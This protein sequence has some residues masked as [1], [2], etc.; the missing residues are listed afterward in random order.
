MAEVSAS[1]APSSHAISITHPSAPHDGFGEQIK[2]V[3]YTMLFAEMNQ[4]KY[5]YTPLSSM[6][7]NYNNNPDFVSEK[8]TFLGWLD[9]FAAAGLVVVPG[10]PKVNLFDLLHFVVTNIDKLATSPSLA[11]LREWFW[12]TREENPE[13]NPVLV[14][15]R[16]HRIVLHIRQGNPHDRHAASFQLPWNIYAEIIAHLRRLGTTEHTLEIISQGSLPAD[17]TDSVD[18]VYLDEPLETSFMRMVTA[19]IL[20]VGPSAFSYAA[21]LLAWP[22]KTLVYYMPHCNPPLPNWQIIQNLTT[23]RMHFEYII[24]MT[25]WFDAAR[26]SFRP[27]YEVGFPFR[28]VTDLCRWGG[29]NSIIMGAPDRLP[30]NGNPEFNEICTDYIRGFGIDTIIE[31]GTYLGRTTEFFAKCPGVTTVHS[32]ESNLEYLEKARAWLGAA[33][34]NTNSVTLHHGDSAVILPEILAAVGAPTTTPRILF[35]LDA[36]WER[37]CPLLAELGAIAASGISRDNCLIIIDDFRIPH[38][39]DIPFD[40]FGGHPLDINYVR[41]KL[42][43]VFPNNNLHYEYYAPPR[44]LAQTRGRLVAYPISW[45]GGV[46]A[47]GVI[48]Q[49]LLLQQ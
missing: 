16:R 36:H 13:E 15:P 29:G 39:P 48:S 35:Y 33:A 4:L 3:I 44:R 11:Q 14:S 47:E 24:P 28:V 20:V 17:I 38:R 34:G 6:A 30:F 40:V 45:E 5:V 37:A 1:H 46:K 41:G 26:N 22:D 12:A 49:T 18:A 9:R 7:H 32:I 42:T 43:A 25:V 21:A 27:G 8:E 2:L 10:T 23:P 31:T 19:D